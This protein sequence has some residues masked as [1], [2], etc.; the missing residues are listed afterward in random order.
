MDNNLF[1]DEGSTEQGLKWPRIFGSKHPYEEIIWE[2]RTAKIIKGDG[3]VVFEQNGVEV[4][5]FWSQ[6][7]TD[8]VASKYFRGQL[9][10]QNREYSVK[11][12]IDR[13][14]KTI[15]YWGFKDGFFATAG[16]SENFILDLTWILVNQYAAFN[17]PVWFNVGVHERPQCSACFILAVEDNMQSILDWYRDEGWIFKYGSGAGTNLSKLRSSK[18][19]LS[20][21][22]YSS[23][24]VS[25][26]KGA[27][28]IANSIRSGG[29]TRR[30]AKMVVLNADHPDIKNF[31]YCKKII[32]NMTKALIS[33]GIKDSITADIFDPY[34]L[35][36]YQ[37]ANNSVRVNDEFMRAV[38]ADGYWDLRGVTTGETIETIK[39]RELMDWIADAAWHSADPGMQYDTTI[40]EWHTCPNTGRINASNPCSEYMHLDNSACNLASLNLLKFLK[41]GG[42]FDVELFRKVVDTM[43]TAQ[44]IL[45][46]NAS[47]P[48]QKIGENARNYRELGL[49]YANLGAT[50]MVLG[51]PYDSERGRVLAGQITSLMCGEAYRMSAVLSSIKGPFA[52]YELNM[53][54]MLGIVAKHLGESEKLFEISEMMGIEDGDLHLAS[55]L[56]WRDA[57][58]LGR[59]YGIRNSQMT[60]L[61]PTGTI[62]FMM[63]CDTTGIE[64]ELALVKYKKLVGGGT[65]KLVNTHVPLALRRLG[66]SNEQIEDISKYLMDKE[67]IEG[68][69]HLK[70]EHTPVFDC[71]FKAHNGKR[72]IGYMGHIKMMSTA[73]PFI[74]GAISKTVNLPA[75]ATVEDIKNVF[76][77]GW[78]LGL[79][80]IAVYRDGSKSI[81]PLNTKKEEN[82]AFVEKINGYT[83]IKLPNERPSITHKFN[84]GGFESY[85]TVGFYPDTMKPGET[86]LI[87]AKEGSTIS[88][89]FNTIATLISMCLQSG[90]PLKTL[91]RKFKD[92]RFDP[93]GFT[94]NPEIPTAKSI[95]DYVFR[96]LGMKYLKPEDKEELFGPDHSVVSPTEVRPQLAVESKTDSLLA[97]LVS[98]PFITDAPACVQCGTL[99]IRAGSC[100]SCP[101]CF[102]TTGV[103]N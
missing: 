51:L 83:R 87:A 35:L 59:K 8:I 41:M 55:R 44:D 72:S 53:E 54:P 96:Y 100:Y 86:F 47:Y 46:D 7:A 19:P 93:A 62:A 84:V 85:L 52:G 42:K 71:S 31:I 88:G 74:S 33:G 26:M 99:M 2:N 28:G 89:L 9:S 103:C 81:Q 11:D 91:V 22:G 39:A 17:S 24:P 13:V 27:D 23:G 75:E 66:Y 5:N 77:E 38:Q 29:T 1:T 37:N 65:L 61:A 78:R 56:V 32:E 45:I 10:T 30:A 4:P 102:A 97:E 57:L 50:L 58:D 70:E 3:T 20:K 68:A 15:G 90:V 12:M 80:S 25:F 94:T 67:T 16:D 6:T 64:P 36:P 60:V 34:T 18:E 73:Q 63:D 76:M 14:A 48:T 43:I 95:T 79:K 101:N 92:T 49:G 82:N 69:P 40:N 21:G 98:K